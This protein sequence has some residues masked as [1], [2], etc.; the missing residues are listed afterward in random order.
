M[1]LL[2]SPHSLIPGLPLH[3]WDTDSWLDLVI[4]VVFGSFHPSIFNFSISDFLLFCDFFF[5]TFSLYFRSSLG[6]SFSSSLSV[7]SSNSVSDTTFS[8]S[9]ILAEAILTASM[10][11]DYFTIYYFWYPKGLDKT[12]LLANW[13]TSGTGLDSQLYTSEVLHQTEASGE[14]LDHRVLVLLQLEPVPL[15]AVRAQVV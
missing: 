3:Y 4:L 8:S 10:T 9:R 5:S 6:S 13:S 15:L 2:S 12:C 11:Q 1:I 14:V 7:I